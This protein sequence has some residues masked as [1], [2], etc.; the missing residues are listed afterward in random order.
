MKT[1]EMLKEFTESKN[2][3][4]IKAHVMSEEIRNDPFYHYDYIS[5]LDGVFYWNS[6]FKKP[7]GL[8]FCYNPL[9]VEWEIKKKY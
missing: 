6:D 1:W 5:L 3:I 8:N 2:P 9:Q 4:R 7:Y